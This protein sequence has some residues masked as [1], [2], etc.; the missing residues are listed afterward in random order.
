MPCSS[1]KSCLEQPSPLV[2]HT[3][4][5]TSTLSCPAEQHKGTSQYLR[6]LITPF[7]FLSFIHN[8]CWNNA[9]STPFGC[10]SFIILKS[11]WAHAGLH[12]LSQSHKT[13][14]YLPLIQTNLF[15]L[16]IYLLFG[17]DTILVLSVPQLPQR[18]KY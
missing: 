2:S 8:T 12:S 13:S 14:F 6:S 11:K 5:H 16:L 15:F 7:L 1:H 4:L 17:F 9:N 3:P 10:C 18:S